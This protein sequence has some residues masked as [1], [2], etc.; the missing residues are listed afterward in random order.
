MNFMILTVITQRFVTGRG[1]IT[2]YTVSEVRNSW[3]K[4][5]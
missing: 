3:R 2:N 4:R 1:A 5:K